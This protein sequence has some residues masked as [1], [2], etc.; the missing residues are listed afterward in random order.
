[1]VQ[2]WNWA[3]SGQFPLFEG[4]RSTH[5]TCTNL[6]HHTSI[7]LR[8]AEP[9]T[10]RTG[11]QDHRRRA[12]H[13]PPLPGPQSFLLGF[14]WPCTRPDSQGRRDHW[15]GSRWTLPWPQLWLGAGRA[16]RDTR[17][18]AELPEDCAVIGLLSGPPPLAWIYLSVLPLDGQHQD[19]AQRVQVSWLLA[20]KADTLWAT[21]TEAQLSPQVMPGGRNGSVV[22]TEPGSCSRSAGSL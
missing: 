21:P 4:V 13:F 5:R 3:N 7:L 20:L 16:G 19:S 8:K 18:R 22:W 17:P 14:G 12:P 9:S 10:P 11:P 6:S 1:M 15:L 2:A